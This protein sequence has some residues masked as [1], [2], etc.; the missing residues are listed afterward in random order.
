MA[1]IGMKCYCF[2]SSRAGEKSEFKDRDI[3]PLL[4]QIA[5]ETDTRDLIVAVYLLPGIHQTR[6]TA[7]VRHWLNAG[8]FTTGRGYWRVTQRFPLTDGLPDRFKLIRMR[9]DPE[10]KH[11]PR[12]EHDGYHWVFHYRTFLDQLACLFA[13][14]LHHFRRHHLGLH[15]R[16]GEHSAN[17]WALDTTRQMGFSVEG[18]RLKTPRRTRRSLHGFLPKIRDRLD[19]YARFRRLRAGSNLLITHDPRGQYNGQWTILVRPM[20]RNA[21]RLVIQTADGKVWRWPL[22]WIKIAE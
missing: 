15:P 20:R 12:I 6:G 1:R 10:T 13:H 9:L 11:Y 2:T 22:S 21:K 3:V 4:E 19:P 18:K 16:E 8:D 7:Y 5:S 14:E 17:Q